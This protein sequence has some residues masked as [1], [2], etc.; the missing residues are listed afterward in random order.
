MITNPSID[1]QPRK[2][3]VATNFSNPSSH[4]VSPAHRFLLFPLFFLFSFSFL[5][6]KKTFV[7]P[8]WIP[9]RA[10]LANPP[11][12]F[13]SQENKIKKT[14]SL[15]LQ[16]ENP[17]FSGNLQP[18]NGFPG[19]LQLA[20]RIRLDWRYS[21]P[22]SHLLCPF[23]HLQL[24]PPDPE[25]FFQCRV[26]TIH[27]NNCGFFLVSFFCPDEN[28]GVYITPYCFAFVNF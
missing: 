5:F 18:E 12:L 9:K 28:F 10:S 7:F 23:L 22:W 16:L 2:L 27:S 17:E 1:H 15:P 24:A 13:V 3:P 4:P 25:R 26:L 14:E 8:I 11:S 6:F 20:F 19:K 21:R